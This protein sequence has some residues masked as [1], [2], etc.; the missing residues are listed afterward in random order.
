MMRASS[1]SMRHFKDGATLCADAEVCACAVRCA[2]DAACNI[3]AEADARVARRRDA[4]LIR[5]ITRARKAHDACVR[6]DHCAVC[7][8]AHKLRAARVRSRCCVTTSRAT[9]M[10]AMRR[11]RVRETLRRRDACLR[12][13]TRMRA[14]DVRKICVR[15]S[16]FALNFSAYLPRQL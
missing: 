2:S 5:Q 15:V 1:D 4:R 10:Y 11:V 3:R 7:T 12:V 14:R 13:V 6:R 9:L 16:I 8:R